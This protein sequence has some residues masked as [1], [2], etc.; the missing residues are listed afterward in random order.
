MLLYHIVF[1]GVVMEIDSKRL[2]ALAKEL[3]PSWSGTLE[4]LQEFLSN[5]Q[6]QEFVDTY[7]NLHG[8]SEKAAWKRLVAG[9]N[10][11]RSTADF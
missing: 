7:M 4:Q 8:K 10:L 1:E 5:E 9:H 3:A 6:N 11:K 2:D